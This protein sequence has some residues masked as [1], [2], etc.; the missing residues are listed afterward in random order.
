MPKK[1]RRAP[2]SRDKR[3]KKQSLTPDSGPPERW[4]HSPRSIE[5]TDA[6]GIFAA[7]AVHEH[8]L[9]RLVSRKFLSG[10]E[11]EAGMKLHEAYHNAKIEQK[12]SANLEPVRVSSHDP[13]KRYERTPKQEASYH[14][15]RAALRFCHPAVRDT[16]IHVACVGCWP[17]IEQLARLKEGL[18]QLMRH[19]GL[20]E[21]A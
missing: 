15:W 3:F 14:S 16:L 19:Y 11:R 12:I 2:V 7:R 13:H 6:A 5:F 8:V 18:Q 21:I 17:S 9:D 20:K 1:P 10:A 4:Q